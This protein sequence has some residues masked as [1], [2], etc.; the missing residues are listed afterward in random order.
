MSRGFNPERIA[1]QNQGW[2][3][4]LP[5]VN[6]HNNTTPTALKWTKSIGRTP[7]RLL[8]YH[9]CGVAPLLAALKA[10]NRPLG[11]CSDTTICRYILAACSFRNPVANRRRIPAITPTAAR[12]VR[13]LTRLQIKMPVFRLAMK[14]L[15]RNCR[16]K[17]RWSATRSTSRKTIGDISRV[18]LW[19]NT[20]D[21]SVKSAG[22][23]RRSSRVF[24]FLIVA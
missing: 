3:K 6:R 19:R 14:L 12:M 13:A 9:S 4:R 16:R 15:R 17:S 2:A 21:P 24:E 23:Y 1:S 5:G 11:F 18:S 20:P 22:R 8:I 7:L 10:L